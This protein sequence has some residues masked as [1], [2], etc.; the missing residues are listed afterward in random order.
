[1]WNARPFR[2]GER[3]HA[4]F[5]GQ[6]RWVG[7]VVVGVHQDTATYDLQYDHGAG[8][9]EVPAGDI[10]LE[11]AYPQAG[12]G[13]HGGGALG[14]TQADPWGGNSV[15]AGGVGGGGAFEPIDEQAERE[16]QAMRDREE[17]A[18]AIAAQHVQRL[19]QQQAMQMQQAQQ[20]QQPRFQVGDRAS[21]NYAN[22]GYFHPATISAVHPDGTYSLMYDDGLREDGVP[23]A[24]VA[25]LGRPTAPTPPPQPRELQERAAPRQQPAQAA[26]RRRASTPPARPPP[27]IN[28][29]SGDFLGVGSRVQGNWNNL[30]A[31]HPATVLELLPGGAYLL[32]YDDGYEE[33]V[34]AERVLPLGAREAHVFGGA[35]NEAPAKGGT[36]LAPRRRSSSKIKVAEHMRKDFEKERKAKIEVFKLK[37]ED[38]RW[39]EQHGLSGDRGAFQGM[40]A[41]YRLGL[42]Q[43]PACLPPSHHK[44]SRINVFVRSRPLLSDELR[45]GG[46]DVITCDAAEV[47]ASLIL[48]EPKVLVDLS[49]AM[50]NH[51][52]K[53]DSVFGHSASNEQIYQT[54]LRPMVQHLFG[55]R[56]GHGTCFA[57]GQTG[58]GKTV[59]MMGLGADNGVAG[60][61]KGGNAQGLYS[62]VA[63]AIFECVAE[64]ARQ[65]KQY[66]VRAGFFEIYRGK[67]A[68]L[69]N[70]KKKVEVMEDEHGMQQIV[71][72]NCIE[73]GSSE[74][75]LQLLARSDRTTKAT[76]QNEVSS[77][78]HALLQLSVVTVADHSWQEGALQCRLT[79]VDLAGSEWAAK[80]QSDDRSNRLDGAEINKS[81]LCLKECIRALGRPGAHVPFRGSKLTQVLKDSFVGAS[82]RTVMVANVSPCSA[83]CEH[84]LNTLRYAERVKDW[85]A[86]EAAAARRDAGDTAPPAAAPAAAAPPAAARAAA[87]PAAAAPQPAVLPPPDKGGVWGGAVGE[88]RD[89]ARGGELRRSASAVG[90]VGGSGGAA[91]MQMGGG[92]G[93]GGAAKEEAAEEEELSRSLGYGAEQVQAHKAAKALL[94]AE[95]QMLSAHGAAC[96]HAAASLPQEEA[97]LEAAG[98]DGDME[99]YARKMR[100]LMQQKQ[101]QLDAMAAALAEYEQRCAGE[102]AARKQVRGVNLPWA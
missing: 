21:G 19:Q 101:Q 88:M 97:M 91:Q 49:K 6:G 67:C 40:I 96:R 37:Q 61:A 90:A 102:D 58:S 100:A 39:A 45:S 14:A 76:A 34:P 29:S 77:R 42:P 86:A 75:L 35:E 65:G 43:Q 46:F 82:S 55:T 48:H 24:S 11:G 27:N 10:R 80:A 12:N 5:Q 32:Q 4:N 73:V 44:E 59:T 71:G 92:G 93:G 78:S 20:Q 87:A 85:S 9:E 99:G 50:D 95:E 2:R 81:L 26:P 64:A 28:N 15:C 47:G 70:K 17:A 62:Y 13:H 84:S 60:R 36:P 56:G 53:F 94:R 1:M 38:R 8:E 25:P 23:P 33:H 98:R 74:Q 79:L 52:Y 83:C 72:L 22:L 57:Y 63:D 66:A 54:A 89:V 68:D 41:R 18:A 51:H 3:V 31:W 16:Q 69:L 7:A 30:G